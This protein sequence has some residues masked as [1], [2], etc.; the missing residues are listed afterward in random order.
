MSSQAGRAHPRGDLAAV[1][2]AGGA[3][4]R[5]GGVD[6][7]LLDLGGSTPLQR[8]LAALTHCHPVVIAGPRRAT[9]HHITWVQEDPPG[10]GPVAGIAAALSRID[11]AATEWVAVLACD[12]PFMTSGTIDGLH[13]AAQD[14]DG[15]T[16]VDADGRRQPLAAVYRLDTLR[17]ALDALGDPHGTSMRAL[18]AGLDLVELP[19]P[20]AE[21]FDVDDPADLA[22]ARQRVQA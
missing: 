20:G 12:L 4:R 11:D 13:A 15:A 1:V 3:G 6:K 21:S 9:R 14:R 16:L 8:T 19:D 18:L 10:G 5:L 22:A 7:A 17:R 2:L